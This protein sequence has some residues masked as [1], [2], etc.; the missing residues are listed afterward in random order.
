MSHIRIKDLL[1]EQESSGDAADD[2]AVY[3]GETEEG[4]R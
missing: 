3:A 4:R 1:S 2:L